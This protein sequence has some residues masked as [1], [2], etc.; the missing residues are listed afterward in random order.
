MPWENMCPWNLQFLEFHF[1]LISM[2]P[3]SSL[4]ALPVHVN[5]GVF[6]LIAI[7]QKGESYLCRS[8]RKVPVAS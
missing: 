5:T 1:L 3:F 2:L 8:L 7:C 6:H 4:L